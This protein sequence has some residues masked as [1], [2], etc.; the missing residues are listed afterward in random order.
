M[1]EDLGEHHSRA[2]QIFLR[3]HKSLW[4]FLAIALPITVFLPAQIHG[5]NVYDFNLAF[6]EHVVDLL[7][8]GLSLSAALSLFLGLLPGDWH[9]RLVSLAIGVA[10]AVWVQGQLLVWNYGV[11]DGTSPDWSQFPEAA[12]VDSIVWLIIPTLALLFSRAVY[13]QAIAAALALILIQAVPLVM[14]WPDESDISGFHRYQFDD[15]QKF[16]FSQRE[17]VIVLMLDAFQADIFNDILLEEPELAE[18]FE[19]FTYFRNALAGYSKT[20]PSVALMLSGRWYE[21]DRPIQDFVKQSFK[22]DSLPALLRHAGWRVDLFPHVKRVVHVSP[23]IASN[24]RPVFDCSTVRA[25]SGKLL[26]LGLFRA[27]PHWLKPLWLNEYDWQ[28]TRALAALCDSSEHSVSAAQP[29]D[30][31]EAPRSESPHA[32]VRFIENA[33]S[34]SSAAFEQRAFKFYHLMIPHAPFSLDEDLN[35][36]RLPRG[37]EGFRRQSRSAVELVEQLIEAL[38]AAGVYDDALIVVVSDHG[39]GEYVDQVN[40]NDLPDGLLTGLLP[41]N[42]D[43]PGR[44]LA[45]G[46]PLLLVKRP[47]DTGALSISDAPVSLG[48][49]A[50]TMG[51]MLH[52]QRDFPGSDMFTLDEDQARSRRYLFFEFDGWRSSYLPDM[53][54]YSVEGFSWDPNNW[55]RT[56]RLFKA[57]KK[58]AGDSLVEVP[59]NREIGFLPTSRFVGILTEGWSEPQ[60]NGMVW[61]QAKTATMEMHL[62]EDRGAPRAIHFDIM[63]FLARGALES[64]RIRVSVNGAYADEWS[65]AGRGWQSIS[66][67]EAVTGDEA[68]SIDFEFPDA[69]APFNH[70]Y[71]LDRRMLGMALYGM[72]IEAHD[73]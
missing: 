69:D 21:N 24:A 42:A 35:V 45:S 37:A 44:H 20:Y 34:L 63:P 28:L 4:A 72:R 43:I 60:S 57:S 53:I 65:L 18:T 16:S 12:V 25:E 17:N 1:S 14:D 29:I 50:A 7:L 51:Q 59:V 8:I 48:D 6:S 5:S 49:L 10:L 31:G 70:G 55:R 36:S 26:D 3:L 68:L 11:L 33:R 13:S 9:R 27:S 46:L 64:A 73:R 61:S 52:L 47:G 40:L 38:K 54:E 15:A 58:N 56:G 66:I 19:G 67:P 22:Q 2:R 32:A 23:E 62:S 71:S 30:P 41:E 39:G